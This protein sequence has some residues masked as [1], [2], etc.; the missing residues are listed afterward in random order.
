MTRTRTLLGIDPGR[1]SLGIVALEMR[2]RAP[3]IALALG[4]T[5]KTGRK[6]M[7]DGLLVTAYWHPAEPQ[8]EPVEAFLQAPGRMGR[9]HAGHKEHIAAVSGMLRDHIRRQVLTSFSRLNGSAGPVLAAVEGYVRYFGKSGANIDQAITDSAEAARYAE[10]VRCTCGV[11]PVR[12]V[13]SDWKVAVLGRGAGRLDA[14]ATTKLAQQL[15]PGL[16]V[17]LPEALANVNHTVAA[18]CMAL[19][20]GRPHG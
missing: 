4:V 20:A 10:M 6:T 5:A 8:N 18:A 16:G 11:E 19:Y 7:P 9:R 1:T 17:H 3:T 15:L 14:T 12:P 13:A 2:G